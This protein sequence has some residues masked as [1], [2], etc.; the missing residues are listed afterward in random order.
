MVKLWFLSADLHEPN[1]ARLLL[2]PPKGP[3]LL[4]CYSANHYFYMLICCGCIVVDAGIHIWI[5]CEFLYIFICIAVTNFWLIFKKCNLKS[6]RK[7]EHCR[8]HGYMSF[9]QF[10]QLKEEMFVRDRVFQKTRALLSKTA[11]AQVSRK[12]NFQKKCR[13]YLFRNKERE[14]R[15]IQDNLLA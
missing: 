4:P 1:F 15:K 7:P 14:G 9:P 3:L 11:G 10:L 6:L 13:N 2:F 8:S 5:L 12:F